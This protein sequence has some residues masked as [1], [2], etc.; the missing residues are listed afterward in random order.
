MIK[1]VYFAA[2]CFWGVEK[3]FY[4]LNGVIS[5]CVGYCGGTTSNPCYEQVCRGNTNHAETVEVVYDTSVITFEKLLDIFWNMHD[6]TLVNRQGYDVGSQYRTHIFVDDDH[7][8]EK[9][10]L[11]KINFAKYLKKEIAT[12]IS[13]ITQFYKAEDY[14]QKYFLK[15]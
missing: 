13:V 8:M 14:H 4:N 9:A 10:L 7:D 1:K 12:K 15:N 5:T 11:S 3:V 6:P 2:G